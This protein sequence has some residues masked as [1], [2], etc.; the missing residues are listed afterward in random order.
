MA[1]SV[2][3]F[4]GCPTRR[5]EV[6]FQ[7]YRAELVLLLALVMF[8]LTLIIFTCVSV[9]VSI[10]AVDHLGAP[11]C[12]CLAGSVNSSIGDNSLS[13]GLMEHPHLHLK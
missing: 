12:I 5:K 3:Y 10:P 11:V 2:P 6:D 4:S 8:Y 13:S 1:S 9:Q 7:K